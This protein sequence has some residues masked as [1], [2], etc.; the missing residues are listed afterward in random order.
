VDGDGFDDGAAGLG[1]SDGDEIGG[2]GGSL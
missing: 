2:Y 1:G